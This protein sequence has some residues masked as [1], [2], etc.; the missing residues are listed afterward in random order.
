[1]FGDGLASILQLNGTARYWRN[2]GDGRF[3]P[4]RSLSLRPGRGRTWA[5]RAC[6]WPTSTA[7][8]APTCWSPPLPAPATG[9]WPATAASTRRLSSRVS[10]APTVSLS[11]PLVRLI[12][13]DGD[14]ITDA[15]RTGDQFELF[16]SDRGASFNRVQVLQRGGDVPGRHLRRSP[17]VP[18]GHDRRRAHRHRPGPRRQHQLL[19]LP[20]IRHLGRQGRHAQ[21]APLLR[22]RQPTPAPGSTRG[23][24]CS[25]T[26]TA[27]AA[28]T[29]STSATAR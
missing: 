27:T 17:G 15:L 4:P 18:G 23:G 9:R 6:S 19:A 21:P 22:R 28:P 10:H 5:T 16:Y 7:T 1:M 29:S 11:D 12:D 25:A 2:R 3:D 8:A 24:C 13:L 26:S 14:G 20:G